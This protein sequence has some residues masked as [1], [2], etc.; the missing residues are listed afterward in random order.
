MEIESEKIKTIIVNEYNNSTG[1]YYSELL[2]PEDIEEFARNCTMKIF[3]YIASITQPLKTHIMEEQK[4]I[5]TNVIRTKLAVDTLK[6]ALRRDN[7]FFLVWKANIAIQF[8]NEYFK[9]TALPLSVEH[10]KEWVLEI[11]NIAAEN[12][13]LLLIAE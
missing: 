2:E 12:F 8:Y 7:S 11:S 6:D 4:L 13:L 5:N 3:D 10:R 9:R 1:Q